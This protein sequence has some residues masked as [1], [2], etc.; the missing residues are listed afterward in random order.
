MSD[1]FPSTARS[2]LHRIAREQAE[3]RAPGLMAGVVRDG[4][5]VWTGARGRVDDT[6]PSSDTQ[7]RI[8]S[9][10][11]TFTAVLVARLRDEGRLDFADPLERHI[12]GTPL[13][14]RTIAQ[15][16]SHTSGAQA[17][18]DGPWWERTPGDDW[19]ALSSTFD[20]H[21]VKHPGSRRYHYSNL[22]FAILGEVVARHRGRS[23]WDALRG[24]ILEPLELRRTTYLPK[25]PH[26]EGY[27]VHPW[28][29]LI[30]PEPAHDAGAMAPAG[31]L[32]ST[33]GDLARWAAF[34][35][36]DTG[37]VLSP[38]T[39]AELRDP[40]ILERAPEWTNG[41]GLGLRVL[42]QNGRTMVGHQ[43]SMPGFLADLLIDVDE[44]VG[45]VMLANTTSGV[46]GV[47]ADLVGI[48]LDAEP[49]LP[50]EWTPVDAL[51]DSVLEIVGQWYWGPAAFV[52][53]ARGRELLELTRM[54]GGE[55][56]RFRSNGDGTWIGLDGYYAGE[57]LRVVREG[58]ERGGSTRGGAGD[59]RVSHLDLATFTFTREPY[60]PEAPVPGG[61]DPA[62][63]SGLDQPAS[64][65]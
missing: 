31:Q 35:G 45:A 17:E 50:A 33:I 62:G 41:Y 65:A 42:R 16:L 44:Q 15:L 22:G 27:A 55:R 26:A 38:A 3:A 21:T 56:V 46:G 32:W 39:L 12:T 60:D 49:R 34:I 57:T 1:L 9:I 58:A 59:C 63:W 5:L 24:E 48:V 7:S 13:G 37:G 19:P 20:A 2:L 64:D 11:K 28:A 10:T 54:S 61:V 53:R 43:G 4:A 40:V 14:D 36:G 30:L 8:G 47:A 6:V 23:W 25:A 52:L 29:D 18:R 51:D